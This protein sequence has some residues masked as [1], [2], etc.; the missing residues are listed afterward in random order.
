MPPCSK[1]SFSSSSSKRFLT[2]NPDYL[3]ARGRL[4]R[5]PDQYGRA[6]YLLVAR[7]HWR[8]VEPDGGTAIVEFEPFARLLGQS[9]TLR[10]AV[11]ELLTYDGLPVEGRDVRVQY[12]KATANGVTIESPVFCY[13]T[14]A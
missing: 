9:A 7:D 8:W 11:D 5:P 14:P 2:A 10:G 12:D 6:Q 13:T 3:H 4:P 1:A